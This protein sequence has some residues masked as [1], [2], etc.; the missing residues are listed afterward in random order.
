[1]SLLRSILLFLLL[2]A[3]APGALA[4]S[5]CSADL[6][7]ALQGALDID[8]GARVTTAREALARDIE[9]D[10]ARW[11]SSSGASVYGSWISD[12]PTDSVGLREYEGGVNV[13]VR[14]PAEKHA[15]EAEGR[16]ALEA[17]SIAEAVRVLML[18]G[19]VREAYWDLAA[20]EVVL[21]RAQHEVEHL[22]EIDDLLALRVARGD[23][24]PLERDLTR[25]EVATA[26]ADAA[27]AR[28]GVAAQRAAWRALTGCDEAPPIRR[29]REALNRTETGDPDPRLGLAAA[30]R[31]I[32]Q[33][34]LDAARARPGQA[35]TLGVL[36]R[37][38]R[39][40]GG[41][42][43]IDAIGINVTV[44]LGSSGSRVRARGEA[45]QRLAEA[46][47]GSALVI[48]D[49]ERDRIAARARLAAARTAA[50]A[51]RTRRAH[52]EQALVRATR[53]HEAGQ[54]DTLALLRVEGLAAE[55]RLAEALS[56]IE[57]A[58]AIARHNQLQGVL[59]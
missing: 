32:A 43:W 9:D 40:Q 44:P 20:A 12:A 59:P 11:L 49:L 51:S 23:A 3:A 57:V 13:P 30:E 52:A 34:S 24:A 55:A 37:R 58:R 39:G 50:E 45:A 47:A 25:L 2:G 21:E 41:A 22:Q 18:A 28:G 19:E 38:E 42:P 36:M 14:L 56:D 27:A 7:G 46:D 16:A 54:W 10:G 33:A 53:A 35:P 5:A 48:R 1:V 6:A 8:P 31:A 26:E 15:L 29:E 4:A 17:A